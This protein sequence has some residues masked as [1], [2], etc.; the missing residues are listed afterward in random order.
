VYASLLQQKMGFD[1]S[2]IGIKN[3]PVSGLF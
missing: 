3:K 2:K 1:Y